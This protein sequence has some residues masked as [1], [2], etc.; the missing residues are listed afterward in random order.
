MVNKI[1]PQCSTSCNNNLKA[2]GR[3]RWSAQFNQM[4]SN[5]KIGIEIFQYFQAIP[6]AKL[7]NKTPTKESKINTN[8][9]TACI[10]Q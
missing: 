2:Y 10:F 1:Q 6:G 8:A 4:Q 7:V 5:A 3:D 9:I